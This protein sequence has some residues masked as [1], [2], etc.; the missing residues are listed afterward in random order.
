[1]RSEPYACFSTSFSFDEVVPLEAGKEMTL[2]YRTVFADGE[3][4]PQQVDEYVKRL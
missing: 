1:V 4:K 3:W 2:N